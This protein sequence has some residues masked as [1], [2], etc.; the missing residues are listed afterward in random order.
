M[1][2]LGLSIAALLALGWLAYRWRMEHINALVRQ[3]M[4]AR[5]AERE[6]IARDLHD[7]LLQGIQALLFRLQIWASDPAV[8]PERRNEIA[9][10]VAQ[11]REIVMEGR[12]RILTLRRVDA[13]SA[14]LLESLRAVGSVESAGQMAR[15]EITASGER[16]PLVWD[17]YQQLIDIGREAIRNAHRHAQASRVAM[18]LDY[19]TNSLRLRIVDNGRGIDPQILRAGQRRGHFGL[20][21]M[22]ERATQLGAHFRIESNRTAGTRITITVP[23]GVAFADGRRRRWY[24]REQRRD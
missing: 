11:A 24:R 15:F 9:T 2:V 8:S 20:I 12:D 4:D 10:V 22:R 23:G 17:T 7:T 3:R 16:R 1:T 19:G 18:M 6:R 14:D 21:G 5:H 13:Q